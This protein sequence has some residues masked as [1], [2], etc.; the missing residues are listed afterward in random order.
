MPELTDRTPML[1][2]TSGL[3]WLALTRSQAQLLHQVLNENRADITKRWSPGI[4][5][6]LAQSLCDIERAGGAYIPR[7]PS[8]R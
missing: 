5:D 2:P 7:L 4:F 3:S 1:V 8:Q 6:G